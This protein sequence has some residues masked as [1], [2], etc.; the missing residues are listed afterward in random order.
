[1]TPFSCFLPSMAGLSP[2]REAITRANRLP[3]AEALAALLVSATLG[4]PFLE[5]IEQQA[6]FLATHLRHHDDRNG[7]ESMVQAFPLTS[8]EGK[9]LFCL[10]GTLLRI[11]DSATRDTVI[12]DQISQGA[13]LQHGGQDHPF[14][15]NAASWAM[16]TSSRLHNL[17][18]GLRRLAMKSG[19]PF[20]RHGVERAITMM[21]SQFVLAETL[22]QALRRSRKAEEK[23]FSLAFA[24]LHETALTTEEADRAGREVMAMIESLG[25]H[26]RGVA[27]YDRPSLSLR[28][29]A[30]HPRF[31]RSQT[32]QVMS[33]LQPF[34]VELALRAK[35]G[36]IQLVFD[37]ETSDTLGLSLDLFDALCHM[38]ELNGWNGLGFTVQAYDKRALPLIDHLI[39]L[40]L[41]TDRRITLR[42]VKGDYW[43]KEIRQSQAQ[44]A[45]DY[46]VFTR[47]CHSD[48]SFI[49]CARRALEAPDAL[50][51]QFAT[52]NARSIA[53]IQ[54][55]ASP[56]KP[57]LYE[58]GCRHGMGETLYAP[59]VQPHMRIAQC[60]VLMP[61]GADHQ[62]APFLIRRLIEAGSPSSFLN[63][64]ANGSVTLDELIAD[65]VNQTRSFLPHGMPNTTIS[66]P[67][68]LTLPERQ[69]AHAPDLNDD[70][71]LNF[72]AT[73]LPDTLHAFQAGPMGPAMPRVEG[74]SHPIRNPANHTDQV[75][76]THYARPRDIDAALNAAETDQ[77]WRRMS[78]EDRAIQLDRL[79]E[80]LE[81]DQNPLL[82][83]LIREGG[84]SLAGACNELREAIDLLR[85][86]ASRLRTLSETGLIGAPL[87]TI[88]CI[89]PWNFP[90]ASFIGQIAVALAAG[91]AV[92]A[93]PAE[94][95]PLIAAHLVT[96]FLETGLP[97]RALQLLPGEGNVGA[98][99]VADSRIDGVL[100]TGST[101]VAKT[102]S[103]NCLAVQDALVSPSLFLLIQA[104][105]MPCWWTAR[106]R[107]NKSF[108][109]FWFPLLT[110]Q[111][112]AV[113]RFVCFWC[114]KREQMH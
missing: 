1:M 85:Y 87:G 95:T 6:R 82:A 58:F 35:S 40:S 25:R 57:D 42:L 69:K 107:H 9:A 61:I 13:W 31:E 106:F 36:N 98:S 56:W 59:L 93:K 100:F 27:L 101:A 86:Y 96:L 29:S 15:L 4:E 89:S 22:S 21:G 91:N 20:I 70:L 78:A 64:A 105:R 67:C 46:P 48:V 104:G 12:R 74:R 23:G 94:E 110:A 63:Q 32:A 14:F 37:A 108:P 75:G 88:L 66:L 53:T 92:I 99:L 50:Y 90:L 52:H 7:V 8:P 81:Q 102:I 47:K 43:E 51:P 49:A 68:D 60:R 17:T 83:L 19:A 26:A 18:G 111:V 55:L 97:A 114:R 38:P 16:S 79:A 44:A 80:T 65:P 3:E 5:Q 84:K 62:F 76:I 34:L 2:S 24:A 71:T 112:S 77:I 10:A 73:T 45:R 30:L 11:P 72:F 113:P 33:R 39:T 103:V 41:E 109:I 54:T 28:L